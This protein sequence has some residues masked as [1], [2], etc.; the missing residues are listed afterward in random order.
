[1]PKDYVLPHVEGPVLSG[2]EGLTQ[3]SFHLKTA[4]VLCAEMTL[5]GTRPTCLAI[6][7]AKGGW[8]RL[9]PA[10]RSNIWRSMGLVFQHECLVVP[11]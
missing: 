11:W 9:L 8:A 4:K 1:M 10:L 7:L 6:A 2:V 3:S 5:T